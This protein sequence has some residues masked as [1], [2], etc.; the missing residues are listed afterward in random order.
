MVSASSRSVCAAADLGKDAGGSTRQATRRLAQRR[1]FVVV[2]HDAQALDDAVGWRERDRRCGGRGAGSIAE[3][4]L[5]PVEACDGKMRRFES[6]SSRAAFG[7]HLDQRAIVRTVDDNDRRAR[8]L[9][10][11]GARLLERGDVAEIGDERDAFAIDHDDR[12][13]AGEI[14]E[15]E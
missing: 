13:A 14:R 10:G 8:A 1:D 15:I 12:R 3:Y 9:V 6:D 2:L 11:R 7:E 4:R 5:Q